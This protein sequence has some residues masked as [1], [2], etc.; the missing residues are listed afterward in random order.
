MPDICNIFICLI[1][2]FMHIC[3][4]TRVFFPKI[5]SQPQIS[6][7]LQTL[8]KILRFPTCHT[9]KI[10][11]LLFKDAGNIFMK[12]LSILILKKSKNSYCRSLYLKFFLTGLIFTK[13]NSVC[14]FLSAAYINSYWPW[15]SA[16]RIWPV[17]V[18]FRQWNI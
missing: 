7:I 9:S 15:I 17:H 10:P 4:L 12:I 1:F 6:L 2:M 3:R 8:W 14:I 11:N 16:T 13:W 18:M 5:S